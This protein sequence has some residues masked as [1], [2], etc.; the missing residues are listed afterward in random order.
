MKSLSVSKKGPQQEHDAICYAQ[1]NLIWFDII[2]MIE[3]IY[4]SSVRFLQS[5]SYIIYIFPWEFQLKGVFAWPP[6]FGFPNLSLLGYFFLS[7]MWPD[8]KLKSPCTQVRSA[9]VDSTWVSWISWEFVNCTILVARSK[10]SVSKD[11]VFC[12]SRLYALF[13]IFWKP[14]TSN[15]CKQLHS[16]CC[17]IVCWQR[18]CSWHVPFKFFEPYVNCDFANECFSRG[19]KRQVLSY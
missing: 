2:Y 19:N 13:A 14:P 8:H 17:D 7:V 16:C 9:S 3:C 6:D 12:C 15:G 5:P 1:G 11:L 10:Q 4:W 18:L